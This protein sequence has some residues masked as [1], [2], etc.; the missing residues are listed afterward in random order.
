IVMDG[1]KTLTAVFKEIEEEPVDLEEV[2]AAAEAAIAALPKVITIEDAAAVEA[3]RALVDAVLELDEEAEIEGLAILD[4]AEVALTRLR[5][6][7]IS[8]EQIKAALQDK[9][10]VDFKEKFKGEELALI[11]ELEMGTSTF[12]LS[13][14]SSN[15]DV[16]EID[17]SVAK[18]T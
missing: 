7:S 3:A 16:I 2:I 4:A 13:W 18:V 10:T 1:D 14:S 6:N 17:K 5:G 12:A 8:A 9:N 15:T 11:N